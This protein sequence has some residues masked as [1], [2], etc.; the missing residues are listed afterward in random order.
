MTTL[1]TLGMVLLAIGLALRGVDA[2][3]VFQRKVQYDGSG[4][5][6]QYSSCHT[7]Y[8]NQAKVCTVTVRALNKMKS[9]TYVYYELTNFYQNHQRYAKRSVRSFSSIFDSEPST[10]RTISRTPNRRFRWTL[11]SF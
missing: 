9:P 10:R 4:T 3:E 5:D 8:F 6:D 2:D 1:C 7:E 11:R